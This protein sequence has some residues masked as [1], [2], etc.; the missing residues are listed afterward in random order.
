MQVAQLQLHL[1]P[2]ENHRGQGDHRLRDPLHRHNLSRLCQLRP[3]PCVAFE[4]KL[5]ELRGRA[6]P[7][8]FAAGNFLFSCTAFL[9]HPHPLLH[10][11]RPEVPLLFR[12]NPQFKTHHSL[13][14]NWRAQRYIIFEQGFC[15]ETVGLA[16]K[17]LGGRSEMEKE[18]CCSSHQWDGCWNKECRIGHW[19]RTFH[20]KKRG[21]TNFFSWMTRWTKQAWPAILW[22]GWLCV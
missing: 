7:N 12:I 17:D 10:Q 2:S 5:G 13:L 1:P 4:Q 22:N 15:H 18:K 9:S 19:Q 11:S 8:N 3:L 20:L 6:L 14:A 16:S 21:S